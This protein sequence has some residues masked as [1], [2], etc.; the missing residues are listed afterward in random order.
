MAAAEGALAVT[1]LVDFAMAAAPRVLLEAGAASV[2][3]L[4]WTQRV[5]PWKTTCW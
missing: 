3:Y 1:F 4:A 5:R 2:R